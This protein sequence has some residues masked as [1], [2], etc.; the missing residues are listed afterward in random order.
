MICITPATEK[1][2]K[3]IEEIA[4]ITWPQTFGEIMP[5]EQ[6]VYM[7]DL[8]YTQ[9]ALLDQ[10]NLQ[11]HQFVLLL[12]KGEAM[13]YT[14]YEINYRGIPQLMVHK[15]YVLPKAQGLGI[16]KKAFEYLHHMTQENEQDKITLKVFYKNE[17]AIG[18]YEKEGF[19][20]VGKET[21]AIGKGYRILDYIM[22]K[23]L[24]QL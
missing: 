14:S 13:G 18:F 6:I 16:G 24:S 19:S 21:T 12:Y 23:Q 9:T 2:L 3:T 1:D 5:A 15:I 10:I 11:K 4:R 22:E 17:A 8:M 20:V 7:L